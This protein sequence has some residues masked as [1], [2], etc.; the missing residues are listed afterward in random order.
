MNLL[1]WLHPV[2]NSAWLPPLLLLLALSTVFLFGHD[3][4]RFYRAGH[5]NYISSQS[6]ALAANLSPKHNFLMFTSRWLRTDGTARYQVYHR[7]PIGSYALTKLVMWPFASSL[8]AQIHAARLLMLLGFAGGAALAYLSLCRLVAQRWLALGATLLA[9]SSSYCLYY[10]DMVSS[11]VA[12]LFGMLLTFH[13]AV[14]FCQENR[15]RQLLCK[16]CVALW[17][18]WHTFALLLPFVILGMVKEIVRE[19]EVADTAP[20]RLSSEGGGYV[21]GCSAFGR[22]NQLLSETGSWDAAVRP[23]AAGVQLGQ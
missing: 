18:G 9:F 2:T 6:L 14:V 10:N 19:Q 22:V 15:F 13:G 17:L 7:F 20:P 21:H 12:S 3:R 23:V 4:D 16:S 5:H 11:E 1:Q 8:S